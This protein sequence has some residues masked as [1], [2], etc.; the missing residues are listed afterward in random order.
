MRSCC[1]AV[2]G[3]AAGIESAGKTW[4]DKKGQQQVGPLQPGI[5]L[6]RR[7]HLDTDAVDGIDTLDKPGGVGT[8]VLVDDAG[9]GLEK[10]MPPE[11]PV[12]QRE[13]HDG[14][15]QAEGQVPLVL[16]VQAHLVQGNI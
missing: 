2:P 9:G 7:Q 8:A 11:G 3:L 6:R 1:N 10:G 14:Q 15:E 13:G 12:H 5:R 16:E 4:G